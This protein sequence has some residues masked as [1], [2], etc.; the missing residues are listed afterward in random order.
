MASVKLPHFL[1]GL[2]TVYERNRRY[3]A[4]VT[5]IRA[6]GRHRIERS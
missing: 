6:S 3:R 2:R 4:W 5:M 1:R